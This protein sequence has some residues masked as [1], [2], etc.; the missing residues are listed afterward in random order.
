MMYSVMARPV[1]CVVA[2]PGAVLR[3]IAS[4][5]LAER[6]RVGIGLLAPAHHVQGPS[7][8]RSMN[9]ENSVAPPRES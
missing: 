5:R 1:R 7:A 2:S 4:G 6:R 9:I 3:P 8:G